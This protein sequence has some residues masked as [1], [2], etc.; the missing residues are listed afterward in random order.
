MLIY[1]F[2]REEVVKECDTL[3]D[4]LYYMIKQK[5]IKKGTTYKDMSSVLASSHREYEQSEGM[6]VVKW[7]A[8]FAGEYAYKSLM[9]MYDTVVNSNKVLEYKVTSKMRLWEVVNSASFHGYYEQRSA[10]EHQAYLERIRLIR[11]GWIQ[12]EVKPKSKKRYFDDS[13]RVYR[14][15]RTIREKRQVNEIKNI[16][17]DE[18]EDYEVIKK[19]IRIRGKRSIK[20]LPSEW[21]DDIIS[22]LWTK[23]WKFKQKDKKQYGYFVKI[24]DKE[25]EEDK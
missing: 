19:K 6:G 21:D 3:Y 11:L 13:E 23:C 25:E 1:D 12:N 14:S 5:L 2:A 10:K 17:L 22:H 18:C 20:M 9:V 24:K 8:A 7:L 16:S 15:P 4:V